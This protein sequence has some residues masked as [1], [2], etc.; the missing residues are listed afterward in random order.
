MN[1]KVLGATLTLLTAVLLAAPLLVTAEACCCRGRWRKP[2]IAT[3]EYSIQVWPAPS[4]P[5]DYERITGDNIVMGYRNLATFGTPPLVANPPVGATYGSGGFGLKIA[6]CGEDFE[7]VGEVQKKILLFVIYTDGR[8]MEIS[9]WSFTIVPSEDATA[10]G[11]VG[12]TLEG[13]LMMRN[14]KTIVTSTTGTGIFEGARLIG[15]LTTTPYLVG[16]V[17]F[18]VGVGSGCI[19]FPR[20][21]P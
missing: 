20:G 21:F 6:V 13:W 7:L 11:A 10:L 16:Q 12:D 19:V 3:V 5:A 1:K 15:D 14:G 17:I 4:Q 18:T 9:K 2:T 8:G